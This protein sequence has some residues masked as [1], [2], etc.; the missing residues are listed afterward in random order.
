[1]GH[2]PQRP[3]TAGGRAILTP[4]LVFERGRTTVTWHRSALYVRCGSD[5][6]LLD[7]PPGIENRLSEEQ[8]GRLRAVIVSSGRTQ[9]IGGLIGLLG[10]LEPYRGTAPLDVHTPAG[11][12]RSALL[13]GTWVR[14][15]PNRYPVVVDTH[16]PG[17]AYELGPFVV[18]SHSVPHAEPRWS[19]RP[20]AERAV[21]VALDVVSADARMAWVVGA[22]PS[23]T[24]PRLCAQSD[25]AVVEV[26]VTPWPR[27]EQRWRLSIADAMGA[28]G[29]RTELWLV[30]DD[31]SVR[32]AA[33]A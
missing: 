31:G 8:L 1:M 15:W 24:I 18:T 2:D 28:A 32:S 27:S 5:G 3:A 22:G 17:D 6:I 11:E 4:E 29:P 26:G 12:E 21:G 33:D 25:L 14:G 10:A 7:A 20:F 19:E 13:A 23:S 30:G 16:M 9:S